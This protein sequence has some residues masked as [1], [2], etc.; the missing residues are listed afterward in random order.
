M[1]RIAAP[2]S[3]RITLRLPAKEKALIRR[4]AA[5][6]GESISHFVLSA[7][8]AQ[9]EVIIDKTESVAASSPGSRAPS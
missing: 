1:P 7:A 4:A 8:A 3:K 9:A 5:W 2:R 6:S